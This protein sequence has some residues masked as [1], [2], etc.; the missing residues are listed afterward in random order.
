MKKSRKKQANLDLEVV[1]LKNI[2]R[3]RAE[4]E[5]R[6]DFH[7]IDADNSG[8][9]DLNELQKGLKKYGIKLSVVS[10]ERL[11]RKYDD[12]PDN[13]ID[14]REFVQ[15]KRDIDANSFRKT[16]QLVSRKSNSVNTQRN[17]RRTRDKKIKRHKTRGHKT[18]G[19]KTR[20]HKTR[21]HKK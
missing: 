3:D 4:K 14:I 18:R 21:G 10:T 11:M 7:D 15:L 6:A 20:V 9:I 16:K 8:Y 19:H 1:S 5:I 13:K 12:N 17:K 2:S